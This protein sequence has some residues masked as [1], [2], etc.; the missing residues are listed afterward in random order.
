MQVLNWYWIHITLIEGAVS[1]DG[2]LSPSFNRFVISF[3]ILIKRNPPDPK[4]ALFKKK[5]E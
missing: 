4:T 5:S 2:V 1:E 3:H